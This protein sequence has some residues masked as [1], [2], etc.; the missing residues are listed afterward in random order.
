[1]DLRQPVILEGPSGPLLMQISETIMRL[2][3]SQ[4][5]VILELLIHPHFTLSRTDTIQSRA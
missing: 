5:L 2:V 4:F 1:M 3:S